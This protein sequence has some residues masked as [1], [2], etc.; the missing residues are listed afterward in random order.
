MIV[1]KL[2]ELLKE[3]S[4]T[5]VNIDDDSLLQVHSEILKNKI[6]LRSAFETFYKDMIIQRNQYFNVDGIE[7]EL[8]SGAG[9]FKD[10]NPDLLTSDIRF[11]QNIDIEINAIDMNLESGSVKCIYGINV[12]HH[13]PD[14][15]KFFSEIIRVL[16]FGGGC[17]LIEP[18][19]GLLSALIHK[20][21][22]KDEYFDPNIT[23]WKNSVTGPL[24]H[25]NQALAYVVF[26]RDIEIF[27][28]KY[29]N[30]LSIIEKSYNL[31]ALRYLFSGGL[32]FKQLVPSCFNQV[33]KDIE[34]R[35]S[36]FAK[37]WSLHEMIIIKKIG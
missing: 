11:H 15:D 10:Y 3:P 31:N 7:I 32:N 19:I 6:L 26:E 24:S 18:H 20:N 5:G 8:G 37:L 17:I 30:N 27:N 14:I 9:F 25:A 35:A 36:S 13:L 16:N 1:N 4:I 34:T 28:M 2:R 23:D 33:L 29:G 12:F 22:H 21:L